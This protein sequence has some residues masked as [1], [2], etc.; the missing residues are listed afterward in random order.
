VS[1]TEAPRSPLER[2]GE[3]GL[4]FLA[5]RVIGTLAT[6]R[7][8]GTPHLAPVGFTVDLATATAWIITDGGSAKA[9]NVRR[10]PLAAVSQVDRAR[11][12]S[13]DGEATVHEDPATIEQA[14]ARYAARYRPPRVNPNRVAIALRVHRVMASRSL[15]L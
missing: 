10:S 6:T 2:L 7:A 8:D 5:E 14:V 1:D 4:A 11:W 15:L 12:I 9:A 3:E 13:L